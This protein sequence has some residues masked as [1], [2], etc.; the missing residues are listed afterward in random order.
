MPVNIIGTQPWDNC[1]KDGVATLACIPIALNNII[2]FLVLFAGVVCVFLIIYSGYKFVMSEGDPE[3]ISSARKTL[4]WA[5]GGFLLVVAS[6][7][8]LNFISQF[9]GA[10]QLV[11]PK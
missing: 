11:A 3:K 10:T 8:I 1:V 6:F 7:F 9:T 5:I 4:T 2:S